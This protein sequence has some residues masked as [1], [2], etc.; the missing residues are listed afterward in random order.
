MSWEVIMDEEFEDWINA[1]DRTER[2]RIMM[3]VGLLQELG[4]NLGRPYADTLKSSKHPHLKEL[5]IRSRVILGVSCL[6][7]IRRELPFFWLEVTR[8]AT[9]TGTKPTFRSR[10][11]GLSG[12]WVALLADM[13][14]DHQSNIS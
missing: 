6:R 1:L 10:T 14:R 13:R 4:P 9:N 11:C 12:I 2:T 7:S 3:H 8:E 5:R